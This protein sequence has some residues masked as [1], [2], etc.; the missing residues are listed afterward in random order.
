MYALGIVTLVQQL[1]DFVASQ[2]RYTYDA[3][4]GGPL[5]SLHSWWDSL[6]CLGPEFGYFPNASKACLI[7][8]PQYLRKAKSL[9]H[10]IGVVITDA[11]KHHLGLALGTDGFVKRYVQDKVSLWVGEMEKLSE[12]AVTQPHAAYA[13]LTHVFLHCWSY[14]VRTVPMSAELFYLLDDGLSLHLLPALT[15]QQA[16]HPVD[17]FSKCTFLISDIVATH[18]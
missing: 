14:I 10:G 1:A 11:G 6:I 5:Q 2:M 15:G 8:K 18:L 7:V 16:N 4:A 17:D 3:S 9:F 12:I 13:A